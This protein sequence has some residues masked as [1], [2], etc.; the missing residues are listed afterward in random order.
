MVEIIDCSQNSDEWLRARL[1]IPTASQFATI[2]AKGKGGGESL[3]RKKYLYQLAGE[4]ITGEPAENFTNA[5]MQR[6]HDMEDEA[7]KFYSFMTDE[8]PELVGFIKS[9]RKGCSPDSL[10]GT[11]GALEI[12]TKAP[13]VLIEAITRGD[14]PPEHKAQVQGILWIAEREWCDLFAYWPKMPPFMWRAK[15]DEEYIANLS[16]EVDRFNDELDALVEKITKIGV[17]A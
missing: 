8:A 10:I 3:T 17:A 15:R 11:N 1:G 12:K 13:H 5:H 7:R 9:G 2:L 6:G 16:G 14:F 4:R